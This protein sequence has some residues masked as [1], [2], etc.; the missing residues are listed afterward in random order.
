M[1]KDNKG[2]G[3]MLRALLDSGCSCSIILKKFTDKAKLTQLKEKDQFKYE[4]Y[5]GYFVSSAAASVSFKF[6]EFNKHYKNKL[7]TYEFQGEKVNR[8]KDSTYDMIIGSDLMSDLD[9]D[10]LFSEQRIRI[11]KQP[12][13]YDYIPM[14]TLGELSDPEACNL[15]Y[16]MH[17]QHPILQQEEQ[18]QAKILDAN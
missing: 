7:I 14:K 17:I 11:G 12:E 4:T 15:I 3:K 18:R 2:Q 13:D 9:I 1:L 16:E 8:S 10:L 5:G 6:V